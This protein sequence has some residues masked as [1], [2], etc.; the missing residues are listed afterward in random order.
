MSVP[1]SLFNRNR[2]FDS[3]LITSFDEE[4]GEIKIDGETKI[5]YKKDYWL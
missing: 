5:T 2:D 4:T 3:P 1:L